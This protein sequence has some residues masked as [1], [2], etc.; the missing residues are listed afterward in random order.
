MVKKQ[1]Y[2]TVQQNKSLKRLARKCGKT[3]SEIIRRALEEHVPLIASRAKRLQAWRQI[4]AT[5][6]NR[7]K[8]PRVEAVARGSAKIFTTVS[9]STEPT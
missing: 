9:T 5:V 2:I 3:E 4:E 6:A 8:L 7:T 1:I